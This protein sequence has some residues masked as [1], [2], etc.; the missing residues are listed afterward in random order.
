MGNC[1]S[2]GLTDCFIIETIYS[3]HCHV[4]FNLCLSILPPFYLFFS[5]TIY[6]EIIHLKGMRTPNKQIRLT[7]KGVTAI[8]YRYTKKGV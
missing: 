2:A 1:M 5:V 3:I 4:A 6:Q 8:A 7:P